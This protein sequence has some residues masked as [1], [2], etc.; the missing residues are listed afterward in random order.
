MSHDVGVLVVEVDRGEYV[1]WVRVRGPAE[2]FEQVSVGGGIRIAGR[3]AEHEDGG[4]RGPLR[5]GPWVVVESPGEPS[6]GRSHALELGGSPN[7]SSPATP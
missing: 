2:V 4:I 6:R 1:Q 3:I 7:P 5:S